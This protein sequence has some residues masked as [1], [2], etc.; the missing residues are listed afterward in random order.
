MANQGNQQGNAGNVDVGQAFQGLANQMAGLTNAMGAHGISQLVEPFSGEPSKFREWI[1]AIEKYA[2]LTQ[3]NQ[4]RVKMIAFQASK[5]AVSDFIRRYMA[6]NPNHDWDRLKAELTAR[7]SEVTDPQVAFTLLR[8]V[9]QKHN[10]NVQVYAERLLTLAEEAFQGQAGGIQ[11]AERQL[12]GFFTDGLRDPPLR[13]KIMRDNPPTLQQA[14]RIATQE[15]NL[16]KRFSLRGQDSL[17]EFQFGGRNEQPM[18]IDHFR[19]KRNK[20]CYK[21]HRYGHYANDCRS[22]TKLVEVVMDQTEGQNRSSNRESRPHQ[23]QPP[24]CF[25]CHKI[26]HYRRDCPKLIAQHQ[27]GN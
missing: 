16:R 4:D 6:T 26:G 8:Q 22:K 2:I 19:G 11:G 21:C 18:E 3:A 12:V 13:L 23:K 10:E 15:Q 27:Q 14:V 5:G 24:R 1:K 20:K 17:D 25:E 7:F 9:K